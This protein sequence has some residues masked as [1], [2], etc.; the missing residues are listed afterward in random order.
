VKDSYASESVYSVEHEEVEHARKISM[1]AEAA[2][3]AVTRGIS[4]TPGMGI[5]LAF[6]M[7]TSIV[8]SSPSLIA[9]GL[10]VMKE[11]QTL[12]KKEAEAEHTAA[13]PNANRTPA[14]HAARSAGH[15]VRATK[16]YLCGPPGSA[17]Q[18]LQAVASHLLTTVGVCIYTNN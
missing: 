7:H 2:R 6:S 1:R 4:D 3:T 14:A 15:E 5:S 17:T 11:G 8:T 12:G 18:P 16:R 13:M 10:H 9:F